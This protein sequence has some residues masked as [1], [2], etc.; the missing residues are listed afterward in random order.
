[1]YPCAL[2]ILLILKTL[3][4]LKWS[5]AFINLYAYRNLLTS[6]TE[7]ST[8]VV[9]YRPLGDP[10]CSTVPCLYMCSKGL[11]SPVV[12]LDHSTEILQDLIICNLL[13]LGFLKISILLSLFPWNFTWFLL[14]CVCLILWSLPYFVCCVV[15]QQGSI[16]QKTASACAPAHNER[17]TINR[18]SQRKLFH[19]LPKMS[20][21]IKL[22]CIAMQL[23][24]DMQLRLWRGAHQCK[25]TK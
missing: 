19:N 15:H 1:M 24:C 20:R 25:L 7:L 9:Q 22:P 17:S 21:I 16:L 8:P 3:S 4:L 5:L 6:W 10:Y 23:K 18:F 12:D 11:K 2:Y 14:M 13:Y